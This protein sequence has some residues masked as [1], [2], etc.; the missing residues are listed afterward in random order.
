MDM[1]IMFDSFLCS[2]YEDTIRIC[3]LISAVGG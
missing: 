2:T 3:F 1:D